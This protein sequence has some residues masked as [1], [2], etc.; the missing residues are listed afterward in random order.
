MLPITPRGQRAAH[1]GTAGVARWTRPSNR[2]CRA[3]RHEAASS[4]SKGT[5]WGQKSSKGPIAR[6]PAFAPGSTSESCIRLGASGSRMAGTPGSGP[7]AL[8][9]PMNTMARPYHVPSSSCGCWARERLGSAYAARVE[10]QT[11]GLDHGVTMR[12]CRAVAI[13]E[14]Q[15]LRM[16]IGGRIETDFE[17]PLH[18]GVQAPVS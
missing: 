16:P 5:T 11:L 8:S 18:V 17:K 9:S 12:R 4:W 3:P 10:I 1:G 15:V 13:L 6:R 7:G 2:T 14:L